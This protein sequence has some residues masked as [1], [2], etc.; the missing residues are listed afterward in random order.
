VKPVVYSSLAH[1]DITTAITFYEEEAGAAI[2]NDFVDSLEEACEHL[3]LWP[4]SGSARFS[5]LLGLPGLR[6]WTLQRFPY[7]IFYREQPDSVNVWRVLHE[8][9][10]I[11][12]LLQEY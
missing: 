2:A 6:S 9:R 7:L 1:S 12:S 4:A 8:R 11:P 5:E 10:D 3:S